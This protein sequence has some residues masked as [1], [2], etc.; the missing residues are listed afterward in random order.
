MQSPIPIPLPDRKRLR[1]EGYDY[2]QDGY[3][4]VTAC[5]EAKICCFGDIKDGK[6]VLNPYG[7]IV[8]TQWEWLGEQYPYVELDAFVVMPNHI[9]GILAINTFHNVGDGRDHPP[10]LVSQLKIKPLPELM[11]AFKMTSSKLIHQSGLKSFLWQRS[12]YDHVV[13]D[14]RALNR[15]REY[16]HLNPMQW[17]FDRNY[18]GQDAPL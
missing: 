8:D 15:I 9:H 4:F 17:E 16:I 10:H 2:S 3:Y 11:G 1:L 13:R 12:F 14:E 6:M 5:V 7:Q 18:D